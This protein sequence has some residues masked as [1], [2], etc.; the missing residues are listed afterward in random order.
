MSG[1]RQIQTESG[2]TPVAP[3]SQGMA[4][5]GLVVPAGM[6]GVDPATGA[7]APG[8][9]AAE[10][11]QAIANLATILGAAGSD[12]HHVLKT[13][14]FLVDMADYPAMNEAYAASFPKPYPARTT[15]VVQ[16]LPLGAR[17]EIECIALAGEA[18]DP[19]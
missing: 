18:P 7:L 5:G 4:G 19:S 8:G 12:L 16:A 13:T 3:Y 1:R 2:P 14:V 11:S 9:V 17:V 6:V 15:V 10:A